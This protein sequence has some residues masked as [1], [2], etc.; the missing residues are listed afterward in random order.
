MAGFDISSSLSTLLCQEDEASCFNSGDH[1]NPHDSSCD[2]NFD[3]DTEDIEYIENLVERE[4]QSFQSHNHD[5]CAINLFIWLKCARL[6][7]IQWILNVGTFLLLDL[8]DFF[9]LF[10][11]LWLCSDLDESS[12]RVSIPYSL[13]FSLLLRSVSL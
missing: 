10:S 7:A 9:I 12:V 13:S 1:F 3:L 8:F 2:S 11:I 6:D 4:T 5:D